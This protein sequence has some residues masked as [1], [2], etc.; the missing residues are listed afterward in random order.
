MAVLP[1]YAKDGDAGMDLTATTCSYDKIY[2]G[3][4]YGTGLGIKIPK[5]HVGLL[6]PRSSVYKKDQNLA[7][8]VGVIDSGYTGE[9]KVFFR[10]SFLTTEN[11]QVG[12]RVAQ[13]I[14]M[15]YPQVVFEEVED[16]EQT[17]RGSDGFGSSG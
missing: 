6:F 16:L 5:N 10:S 7:N 12:E 11:Y 8:C 15:P 2:R 17:S 14:I 9:I 13:L 1:A 3:H 4:W